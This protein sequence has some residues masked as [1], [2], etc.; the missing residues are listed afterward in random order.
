MGKHATPR[1]GSLQF[2]PRKRANRILPSVN[3]NA[4]SKK[5]PSLLGFLGYKV[6]MMSAYVRDNTPN[7]L[8]KGQRITIPVTI[9]ECPTIKIF[10]TRFYKD[11][12][13]VGEIL[14]HNLDKEL[15]RKIKL[16]K[17]SNKKIEDF[18]KEFDDVKVI[19]YSQVKKTGIKKSP[20]IL[21]IALS[22]NKDEKLNF[23][24]N[25]LS[26]EISI[27]EVIKEGIVDVR[28]VTIGR[29]LQGTIKRFGLT[30]KAHKSE[31]GQRTLGSG[32]PWHP[33]RVDFHQPRAGQMGFFTRVVYNNKIVYFGDIKEKDINPQEGFKHFGKVKND[34]IIIRGSVQ[35][36]VKRQLILTY[37]LRPSKSQIKKNYEFIELR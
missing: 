18:K 12:K 11:G 23:I 30:L 16:P 4:I 28:G 26:K 21:E 5:E 37:P 35:G 34:Y 22:G 32:G 27:R 25:N 33:S 3:W 29:G 14:N 13:V 2:Y 1:H 8:S 6:G 20:D 7:S 17:Q 15:K 36:P 24:K 10:S 31:K 19:V 9:I